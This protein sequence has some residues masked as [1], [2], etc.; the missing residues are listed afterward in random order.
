MFAIYLF[1]Y[2]FRNIIFGY[3]WLFFLFGY[4]QS[5]PSVC[6]C[7][8]C[9]F[10]FLFFFFFLVRFCC[11]RLSA[12][13]FDVGFW[14]FSII[15]TKLFVFRIDKSVIHSYTH[16]DF[17][18]FFSDGHNRLL[19]FFFDF[20][21]NMNSVWKAEDFRVFRFL[22]I[23]K[24]KNHPRSKKKLF[25][26]SFC[27]LGK[28]FWSCNNKILLLLLF[29]YET[30]LHTHILMPGVSKVTIFYE[31]LLPCPCFFSSFL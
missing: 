21:K 29:L 20:V 16:L 28:F 9:P 13:D 6:V 3:F 7:T 19:F 1:I 22:E 12:T 18:P 30:T 5:V 24:K 10:Y 2:L 23:F 31:I 17:F 15:K 11:C 4:C 8:L 26:V 25:V 14:L 27:K